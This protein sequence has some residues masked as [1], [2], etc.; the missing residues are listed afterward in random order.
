VPGP[1]EV[2]TSNWT[3]IFER[4]PLMNAQKPDDG[5]HG[6]HREM[7]WM[8]SNTPLGDDQVNH[9]CAAAYMSDDLPCDAAA[10]AIPGA[11]GGLPTDHPSWYEEFKKHSFTASLDHAM[12]F[13][14]PMRSDGWQLYDVSCV[15]SSGGRSLT[16]G[17]IYTI[18]G[19]HVCTFTQEVII[20]PV[21]Q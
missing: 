8:R 3:P 11:G 2:L 1:D 12:W 10:R 21:R 20:R 4:K 16:V 15:T 6:A 18:A 17:H 7:Y 19:D 9:C 14:R 13:H 5:R